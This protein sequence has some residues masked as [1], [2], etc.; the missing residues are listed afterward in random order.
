[1]PKPDA[2][3]LFLARFGWALLVTLLNG[4]SHTILLGEGGWYAIDDTG[5]FSAGTHLRTGGGI[6]G[7]VNDLL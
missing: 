2:L 6:P 4:S 1:V 3:S 5:V 7:V